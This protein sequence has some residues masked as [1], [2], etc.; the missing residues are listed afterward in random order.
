[1]SGFLGEGRSRDLMFVSLAGSIAV[2][3]AF[4]VGIR[5][6]AEGVAASFMAAEFLVRLPFLIMLGG[7]ASVTRGDLVSGLAPL[8]VSAGLS[9]LAVGWM[10]EA[11]VAHGV[12]LIAVGVPVAYVLALVCM[13]ATS[14]GRIVLK[15]CLGIMTDGLRAIRP[16]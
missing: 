8:L 9:I 1:M 3:L 12:W 7:K 15:A 5:W 13:S 2:T 11:G 16:A 10:R 4:F 6:G 14:V